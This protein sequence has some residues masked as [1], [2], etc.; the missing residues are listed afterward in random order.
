MMLTGILLAA[1]LH[2]SSWWQ[3]SSV[4][5]PPELSLYNRQLI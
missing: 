4:I 5:N 3:A 2:T 1:Q